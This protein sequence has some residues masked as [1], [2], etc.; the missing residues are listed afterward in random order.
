MRGRAGGR[1]RSSNLLAIFC[2]FPT[3]LDDSD[4]IIVSENCKKQ[5]E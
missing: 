1:F 3:P 5:S 4:G 2:P